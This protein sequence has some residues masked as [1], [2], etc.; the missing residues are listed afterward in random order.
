MGSPRKTRG[1][2][3][4]GIRRIVLPSGKERFRVQL[5]HRGKGNRR[6]HL[7]ATYADARALKEEWHTRGLPPKDA[8]PLSSKLQIIATVND[9]FHERVLDL[10]RRG[11]ASQTTES[12]MTFFRNHWPECAALPMSLLTLDH[13]AEY[14]KRREAAGRTPNTICRELREWRSTMKTARPDLKIPESVFPD[15]NLTRVRHLSPQEYT[16]VFACLRDRHGDLLGDLAELALRGVMR[17]ADVRF[18]KRSYVRLTERL[19]LLPRTKGGPRTVRLSPKALVI[20]K[21]ALARRPRHE[22]VFANPRNGQPYSRPHVGRVWRGAAKAAGLDN[23]TFH[24]LRHHLPTLAVNQ[25]ATPDVLK[26]MGG[27]RSVKMIEC[28]ASVLPPT[29]EKFLNL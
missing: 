9:S 16:R 3:E 25:G 13:V 8:P 24:D 26:A 23:F 22:F 2:I 29:V 11:K 12:I 21:R 14:R 10:R 6:S 17:Q 18:L 27:W 5:G 1:W 15:E 19:L 4:P 7:C 20:L 28:Y